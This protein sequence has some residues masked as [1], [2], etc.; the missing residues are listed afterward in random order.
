MNDG[1][2]HRSLGLPAGFADIWAG[3][4][5]MEY[6]QH[7][8]Q[9]SDRDRYGKIPLYPAVLF[10]VGDVVEIEVRN[11][12]P[13]KAVLRVPL[14]D[15]DDLVFVLSVPVE[16]KVFVRTVWRNRASDGHKTL[17]VSKYARL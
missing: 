9:E 4:F 13:V 7:A 3:D 11:N 8:R 6:S 15:R 17:D 2:Y 10:E 5:D 14:N 12:L 16:K 1:V